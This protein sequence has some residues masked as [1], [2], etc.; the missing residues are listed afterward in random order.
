MALNT[1]AQ[2]TLINEDFQ[3]PL[4]GN[5]TSGPSFAGWTWVSNGRSRRSDNQSDVPDDAYP[6][7]NQVIQFEYTSHE[8][9]YDTTNP[10]QTG[11]AFVLT[12]NT[13]R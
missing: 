1:G 12:L 11:K 5:G 4:Y 6:T 9:Y 2:T 7:P 8:I 13:T 10:W 3:T